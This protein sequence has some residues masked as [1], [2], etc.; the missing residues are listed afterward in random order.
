MRKLGGLVLVSLL[1]LTFGGPAAQ[2]SKNSTVLASVQLNAD[3]VGIEVDDVGGRVY[4]LYSAPASISIRDARTLEELTLIPVGGTASSMVVDQRGAYAYVIGTFGDGVRIIDL[5]TGTVVQPL[6][7]SPYQVVGVTPAAGGVTVT[8]N[9]GLVRRYALS[10]GSLLN[11]TNVGTPLIPGMLGSDLYLAPTDAKVVS[12]PLQDLTG[13]RVPGAPREWQVAPQMQ[14]I[15]GEGAEVVLAG[16][17][18]LQR[19]DTN[20]GS[21]NFRETVSPVMAIDMNPRHLTSR[22]FWSRDDNLKGQLHIT[23]A[24]TLSDIFSF[25][26]DAPISD[27]AVGPGGVFA[28]SQRS[29]RLFSVN[30]SATGAGQPRNVT[31]TLQSTSVTARWKVPAVTGSGGIRRYEAQVSPSGKRCVTTKNSCVIRGLSPN[32]IYELRVRAQNALGWG[33][34]SR[35]VRV[36]TRPAPTPARPAPSVPTNPDKPNQQIS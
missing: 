23:D 28:L 5:S 31:A 12:I 27:I 15:V 9:N 34:D 19:L 10:S 18:G 29:A 13:Q 7:S 30:G 25:E 35:I 36:Q 14:Q 6:T 22:V 20:T 33:T 16:A 32:T 4:V 3:P 1:V 26:I 24:K 11:E 21:T 2:A 17:S 8:L